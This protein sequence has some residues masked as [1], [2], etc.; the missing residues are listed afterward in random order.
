MPVDHPTRQVGLQVSTL[1]GYG[2]YSVMALVLPLEESW[3]GSRYH[4]ELAFLM[5]FNVTMTDFGTFLDIRAVLTSY[6]GFGPS[7]SWLLRK[8][9][10]AE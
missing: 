3:W 1:E 8:R 10:S 2:T 7:I 9:T 4:K 5:R 6:P